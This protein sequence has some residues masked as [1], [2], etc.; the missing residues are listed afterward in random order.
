MANKVELGCNQLR[1]AFQISGKVNGRFSQNFFTEGIGNGGRAWRKVR[2]GVEIEQGK[3]VYVELFGSA[4][5]NC[6][7]SKRTTLA[8]GKVQTDTQ[9]IPWSKRF[10]FEKD[11]KYKGY[12][13][14]GVTCGCRKV[15]DTKGIEKNDVKHLTAFDACD[16]I[17]NLH[18]GD[19]V[20][21]RGNIEYSTYNGQHRV[22]FVPS[23]ISL[24]RPIDFD[25][26]AFQPTANFTQP[27]VLMGVEANK[28]TGEYDV[29]AKVV[30]Y[31]TIEDIELHIEKEF[32]GLAKNLKRLGSYVHIKVFGNIVVD[33]EVV[34]ETISNEW[35][36]QNKMERIASPFT[37]KLVIEG[38]DPDTIDKESYSEAVIEHAME[39]IAGIQRAKSDYGSSDGDNN[40][41]GKSSKSNLDA[42]E[43]D[44]FDLGLD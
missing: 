34:E 33:G 40:D 2:F 30:N 22:M 24:C 25:D 20:F 44:D 7:I 19:S 29:A 37:R 11:P 35:G 13:M 3:T 9:T 10:D 21:V 31:Q 42:D 17:Q 27:I 18:D 1:G 36:R 28:E 32:A 12:G 6:Y 8:G 43:D 4:Q 26:M 16:E 5:D 15:L 14:I 38:V 39:V 23:Q 41:W